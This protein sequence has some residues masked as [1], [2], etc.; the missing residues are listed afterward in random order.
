LTLRSPICCQLIS[1]VLSKENKHN[2]FP[3]IKTVTVTVAKTG[4]IFLILKDGHKF[5]FIFLLFDIR[6]NRIF[7]LQNIYLGSV[8]GKC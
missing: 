5:G 7:D 4:D 8:I 2:R 6:R 1:L 3:V